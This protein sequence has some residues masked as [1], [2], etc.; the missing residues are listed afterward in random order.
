M[1]SSTPKVNIDISKIP[2]K[3]VPIPQHQVPQAIQR[4][5]SAPSPPTH[6]LRQRKGKIHYRALYLGQEI[7]K[8]I[9]HAAQDVK[10]KCKSMRKSMQKLAKATV[11]K[12]A[13]GAFSPKQQTS[14]SAPSSPHL[15]SSSSWN[16][17]PS[18]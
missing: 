1:F 17:W 12:L 11:T 7:K 10:E 9:Q 18:K 3:L 4:A 2:E 8:Y 5:L 13:A 16:I 6:N 14:A 15:S